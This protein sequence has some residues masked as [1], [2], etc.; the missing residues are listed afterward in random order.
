MPLKILYILSEYPQ[1]SQTY[2]QTEVKEVSKTHFVKIISLSV[3]NTPST[4]YFPFV[5]ANTPKEV[6]EII[7]EFKPNFL[8]TH[9]LSNAK[10]LFK[11]SLKT[12]IPFTIRAHSFDAFV[13]QTINQIPDFLNSASKNINHERCKG[14]V[15]LPFT[16]NF[17]TDSCA[18]LPDKLVDAPPVMDVEQFYDLSEN[19]DAVMNVGACLPKKK[20]DDFLYL[21][22]IYPKKTYNLYA[23]GY[24]VKELAFKGLSMKASVNFISKI[25]HSKMLKEYKKHS[26]LVYTADFEMKTVGWPMATIEAMA[27]GVMVCMPLIREDLKEYLGDGVHYYKNINDVVEIIS[28]TIDEEKRIENSAFALKYDVSKH[29]SKLTDLWK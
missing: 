14:V 5:L 9:Y 10:I 24:N 2:I 17:L 18:I 21:A 3:P 28:G 26:F 15:V 22:S 4:E 1:L 7:D 20:M 12:G 25:P 8:H 27:A 6:F 23:I 16:R 11:F 13:D 19:G 29:I